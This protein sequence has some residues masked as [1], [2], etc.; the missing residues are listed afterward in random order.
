MAIDCIKSAS[1]STRS[2]SRISAST[3]GIN[4]Y[5][6]QRLA[7]LLLASNS[8]GCN[9][10]AGF[11]KRFSIDG[12]YSGA[13]LVD[14]NHEVIRHREFNVVAIY[15]K[16]AFAGVLGPITVPPAET[17]VPSERTALMVV[18]FRYSSETES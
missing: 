17:V 8:H 13:V 16:R 14:H 10:Y 7:A 11:S 1:I 12:N 4:G 5:N 15:L 2:F 9:I 18:T 3:R 6:R